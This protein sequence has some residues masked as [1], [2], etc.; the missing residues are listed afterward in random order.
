MAGEAVVHITADNWKSEVL[1]SP[2]PVL[3]DFWATW[4]GPCR[5][6]SPIL[7]AISVELAGKLKIAKVNVDDNQA[8]A[9]EFKI[10]AIPTML[11]FSKGVVREQMTGALGKPALLDKLGAYL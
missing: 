7:D 11:V 10:R 2:I 3:V 9:T 5:A 8:L 6:I 1:E 4:C